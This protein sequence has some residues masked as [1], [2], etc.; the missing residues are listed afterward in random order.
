MPIEKKLK[1]S[2]ATRQGTFIVNRFVIDLTSSKKKKDEAVRSEP[3][4]PAMPKVAS[5]LIDGLLSVEVP[6][7][8]QCRNLCQDVH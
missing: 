6:S 3:T 1:T 4:T 5:T 2:S 7:W 8:P